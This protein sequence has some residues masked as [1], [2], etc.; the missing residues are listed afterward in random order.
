M[1]KPLKK[2]LKDKTYVF[3]W[4]NIKWFL[5]E[6]MLIYSTKESFFSKKRIE[7]AIGFVIAEWGMIFFLLKKYEMMTATDFGIWAS[8]QF[9]VAGYMVNQIQKEKELLMPDPELPNEEPEMQIDDEDIEEG[10]IN[11]P[12]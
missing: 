1:K 5:S 6:F 10:D 12:K 2:P 7:S 11:D 9:V 3:G 8:I 4:T